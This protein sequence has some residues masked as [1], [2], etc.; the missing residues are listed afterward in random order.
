M[1]KIILCLGISIVTK[2]YHCLNIYM[3][4]CKFP[5]LLYH[6]KIIFTHGKHTLTYYAGAY[7]YSN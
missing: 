7:K 4:Y 1:N 3:Y 6:D 2:Y 5:N